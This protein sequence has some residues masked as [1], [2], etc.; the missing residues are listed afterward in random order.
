MMLFISHNEAGFETKEF[1]TDNEF[2]CLEDHLKAIN[3]VPNFCAAQEHVPEI[4]R[5]IR[6]VKESHR[7]TYHSTPYSC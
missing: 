4:E 7:A 2:R 1:H 6:L 3:T 5:L